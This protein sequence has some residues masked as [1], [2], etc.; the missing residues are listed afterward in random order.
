MSC[1]QSLWKEIG[2]DVRC[3]VLKLSACGRFG[4]VG[5]PMVDGSFAM[6]TMPGTGQSLC[7]ELP[8]KPPWVSLA[9][10]R[11]TLLNLV[12][13]GEG[14]E[15]FESERVSYD[16]S[17]TTTADGSPRPRLS[18]DN[19]PSVLSFSLLFPSLLVLCTAQI[20]GDSGQKTLVPGST[21]SE[22]TF[23]TMW[24]VAYSVSIRQLSRCARLVASDMQERC[25]AA[26][27][28]SLQPF[29]DRFS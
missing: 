7:K 9:G 21:R 25:G 14:P 10:F 15:S 8:G 19:D 20:R 13:P 11:L 23:E 12:V 2:H 5:R 18:S 26:Q 22:A 24:R 17:I 28:I 27:P 16:R 3:G 4:H 6:V 1:L 29:H